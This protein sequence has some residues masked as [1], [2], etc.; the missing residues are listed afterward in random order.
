MVI[1][2]KKQTLHKKN[3][4]VSHKTKRKQ[5]LAV[6][7]ILCGL[8]GMSQSRIYVQAAQDMQAVQEG[9]PTNGV[10]DGTETAFQNQIMVAEKKVDMKA[11]PSTEAETLI[12]YEKGDLIY[13]TG[14]A[15]GWYLAIYQDKKGYVEKESLEAQKIDIEGL[16]AEMAARAQE[17]K[18]VIEAVEKYRAEA[19]R[20]KIWGGV[21]ITL[22]AAIFAFGIFSAV[23]TKQAETSGKARKRNLEIEDWNV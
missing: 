21:I 12:T 14:E 13:V 17:G 11:E 2:M 18:L 4:V 8:F 22:V 10:Q 3:K 15:D 7:G 19:R 16:D 23:R 6:A 20:S 9:Q 1:K 5:M